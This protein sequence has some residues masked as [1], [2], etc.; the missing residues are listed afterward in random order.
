MSI[1]ID[2]YSIMDFGRVCARSWPCVITRIR[3]LVLYTLRAEPTPTKT[4]YLEMLDGGRHGHHSDADD[5]VP[6]FLGPPHRRDPKLVML[7]ADGLRRQSKFQ[8][9]I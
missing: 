4:L 5:P 2:E 6:Q 1:W 3:A 8:S 7:R 9:D